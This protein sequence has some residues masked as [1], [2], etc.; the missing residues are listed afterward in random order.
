MF[1]TRQSGIWCNEDDY[2]VRHVRDQEAS[3]LSVAEYCQRHGLCAG[4]FYTWRRHSRGG[5]AADAQVCFTE[6]GRVSAEAPQWAAEV[7][8]ASGAVVRV[9]GSADAQLLRTLFEALG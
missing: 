1:L 3:G 4:T 7:V 2:R 8:L 5:P 9:D 6:I